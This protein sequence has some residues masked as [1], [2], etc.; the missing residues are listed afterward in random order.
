VSELGVQADR[1]TGGARP[2][3]AWLAFA[4]IRT[5]ARAMCGILTDRN[6]RGLCRM[7][8]SL[9]KDLMADAVTPTAYDR[10]GV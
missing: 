3:A 10:K 7:I 8:E 4:M 2:A 1:V 5:I 9:A 6:Q